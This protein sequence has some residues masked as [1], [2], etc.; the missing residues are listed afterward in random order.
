MVISWPEPTLKP[1]TVIEDE[2]VFLNEMNAC[3]DVFQDEFPPSLE[4]KIVSVPTVVAFGS[5]ANAVTEQQRTIHMAKI[6]ARNFLLSAP[7]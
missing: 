6:T 4:E 7:L 5:A 1:P 3:P 2:L